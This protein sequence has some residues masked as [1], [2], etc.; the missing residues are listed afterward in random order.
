MDDEL[1]VWHRVWQWLSDVVSDHREIATPA[2]F[3]QPR[4][5]AAHVVVEHGR[6]DPLILDDAVVPVEHALHEVVAE[7]SGS[8]GDEEALPGHLGEVVDELV[9]DVVEVAP[10][11]I[12]EGLD[13]FLQ[14][15]H[16]RGLRS[17]GTAGDRSAW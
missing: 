2:E 3:I 8:S 6:V 11:E 5:D 16:A 12:G 17:P 1:E 9:D 15:C 13:R 10:K 14:V 7:E 4:R